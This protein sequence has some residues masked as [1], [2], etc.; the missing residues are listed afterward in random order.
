VAGNSFKS[1]LQSIP[2]TREDMGPLLAVVAIALV[3]HVLPAVMASRATGL[4]VRALSVYFDGHMYIE[5]AKSFPLPYPPESFDYMGHAPGYPALIYLGRLLTPS[6]LIDWGRLALMA[7]WLPAA[8][9]AGAFYM[10]CRCVGERPFWPSVLFAVANPRWATLAAS[11]HSEPLA[12]L[13]ATLCLAAYLNGRLALSM[14]LLAWASLCRFPAILL[15]L[16]LAVGVLVQR[17]DVRLRSFVLLSLPLLAFGLWNLY[18]SVRAPNFQGLY[19]SHR[20][21]GEFAFT[22][23]F[24]AL[25]DYTRWLFGWGTF[26]QIMGNPAG[27]PVVMAAAV[28]LLSVVVG[29]R[30][31]E[32]PLWVLPLWVLVIVLFHGS[33]SG[34]TW[35]FTRLAI[36][37]WPASLLILWRWVG[38]RASTA[39][40]IAICVVLAGYSFWAAARD[41]PGAVAFQTSRQPFLADAI[42]RLSS[43]QPGWVDFRALIHK[44]TDGL[45]VAPGAH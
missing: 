45:K 13:A 8:L 24:L 25:F 10:V 23:P 20:I 39:V 44:A 41:I 27:G 37:A 5:I 18:L 28:Y 38:T 32:R 17:R 14:V 42:V 19:A 26:A 7:S 11:A 22:W 2:L 16:P 15:G 43:D 29:F 31:R 3:F 6:A 34:L 4:P 12:M 9:A 36:L 1:P 35:D 30:R 40:L 33:L 21:T